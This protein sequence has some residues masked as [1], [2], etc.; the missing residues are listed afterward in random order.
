[1]V[2]P[3]PRGPH[4]VYDIYS[5]SYLRLF[6]GPFCST[7]DMRPIMGKD[8][9]EDELDISTIIKQKLSLPSHMALT[10]GNN[11]RVIYDFNF[12]PC[13]PCRD[14]ANEKLVFSTII[15]PQLILLPLS[16]PDH[17]EQPG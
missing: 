14:M 3:G 16:G 11:Q 12:P 15:K 8:M 6:D 13:H 1:M 10:I 5:L 2:P 9:T 17:R 4:E 7:I